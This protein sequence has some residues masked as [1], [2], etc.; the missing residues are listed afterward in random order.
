MACECSV[1][2]SDLKSSASKLTCGHSFCNGCIKSW[3]LKGAN[4]TACPMCRRPIYF[5]GFHKVRESWDEEAWENKCTEIYGEALDRVFEEAQE[6]ADSLP[7]KW[8][9][10]IWR[11]VIE[12]FKDLDK[13][14][15]ALK[16]YNAPL[17]AIEDA[18][19]EDD[20]YSDRH[21][22][23]WE[24]DDEP[25][26]ELAL[27]YPGKAGGEGRCGKRGRA[28]QDEWCTMNLVLIL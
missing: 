7:P 2:Y 8:G 25:A 20:Y 13:T 1:C 16:A 22:N 17:Y 19:D 27:R 11:E 18:F 26:K 15:R 4:G 9:A 28:R 5:S 24:W 23:K 12:D 14:L 6:F 10:R 3:Y 21:L